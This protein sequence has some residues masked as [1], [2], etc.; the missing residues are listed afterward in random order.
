LAPAT[1]SDAA[2]TQ[3]RPRRRPISASELRGQF[4]Y[5]VDAAAAEQKITGKIS[6]ARLQSGSLNDM[7]FGQTVTALSGKQ[8]SVVVNGL[9]EQHTVSGSTVTVT[10]AAG[11]IEDLG[12]FWVSGTTAGLVVGKQLVRVA[13][14]PAVGQYSVVEATGVYTFNASETSICSFFYEYG[15]TTMNSLAIAN[16]LMG[17]MPSVEIHMQNYYVNN[18]GTLSSLQ[19]K[20]NATHGSKLDW[21]FKSNDYTMQD[22]EF[23]AFADASGNVGSYSFN[24]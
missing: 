16:P 22:F 10:N 23:V 1:C 14:A 21:K 9:P 24:E 2:P 8:I 18:L 6:F 17:A 12:V 7:F 19:I 15:V 13:S 11:G 4:K 20:L 3:A 5:A